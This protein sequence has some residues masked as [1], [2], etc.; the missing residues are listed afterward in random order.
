MSIAIVTDSHSSITPE[1]ARRLGVYLLPAPFFI[2]GVSYYE[3]VDIGREDFFQLLKNSSNVS[4]SQSSPSE[5][6][7][8]WDEALKDHDEILYMPISSGLSSSCVNAKALAAEDPYKGRVFV[9]D[10]GRVSTPMHCTILDAL[11]MIKKGISASVIRDILEKYRDEEIIYLAVDTLEYLRRGG[12]ISQTA[13]SIGSILQIKPVL[14]L[15]TGILTPHRNCHG[16]VRAR[17]MMIEDIKNDLQT[18][19]QHAW[20]TGRYYL[21]TATSADPETTSDWIRQIEEEF[22][23]VP[24]LSDYLSLGVCCH[25]GPGAL[26]IGVSVMPDIDDQSAE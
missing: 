11:N 10:N 20:E 3:N 2:D 23:D 21:M 22:P 19:F 25:S 26:G 15:T 17:K 6:M 1:E 7:S 24:I 9:V 16:M 13:A 18:R 14:K 4:T 12:R 5:V 8:I